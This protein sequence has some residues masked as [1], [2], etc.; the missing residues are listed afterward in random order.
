MALRENAAPIVIV[1]VGYRAHLNHIEV[2]MPGS[3]A[4]RYGYLCK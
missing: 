1:P 2:R 4:T 3:D